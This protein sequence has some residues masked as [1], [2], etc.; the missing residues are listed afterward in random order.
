MKGI[1]ITKEKLED[2][3]EKDKLTTYQIADKLNCCQATVW[4]LLI[5]YNIKRRKPHELNSNVPSKEILIDLYQNKKLSTWKI[6]K[7]YGYSRGTIHRKLGEFGINIRDLADSHI[8]HQRKN[9]SGDLLEKAYIIG[10]RLGDLGVRKQY[11]NSKTI[12]IASGSTIDEQITLI[13]NMFEE[14]GKVWIQ[15]TSKGK[16]NIQ[17]NLDMSFKFLLSKEFPEWIL[18]KKGYFFSFLAGFTDAEGT[19][20]KS[21]NCDY[22]SLGNYDKKLLFIIYNN[23]NRLGIRCN[24]PHSDNR[25]G[26]ANSQGYKYNSNYWSLR[27]NKK[28]DLMNLLVLLE[29]FIK[30]PQKVKA[31]NR[32]IENINMRNELYGKR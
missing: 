22:Y 10:F 9:F 21:H 6:E 19:I 28:T 26:K 31:L 25:K 11:P 4:K 29:P 15:K 13:K 2:M 1:K 3:Y 20:S 32:A 12:C 8:I 14:Y 7:I 23:L 17:A 24:M 18:E 16:I 5:K 27:I 30:H